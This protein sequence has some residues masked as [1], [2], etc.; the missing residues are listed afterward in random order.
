M[1]SGL[2]WGSHRA[3]ILTQPKKEKSSESLRRRI[4]ASPHHQPAAFTSHLYDCLDNLASRRP[5]FAF[6]RF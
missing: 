3:L 6:T 4:A 2:V 5:A 1:T